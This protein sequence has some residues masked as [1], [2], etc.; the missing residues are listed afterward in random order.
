MP[1]DRRYSLPSPHS[2]RDKDFTV[3]HRRSFS[4]KRLEKQGGMLPSLWN[5]APPR[6]PESDGASL[7][8]ED[9]QK[10]LLR[11]YKRSQNNA[12]LVLWMPDRELHQTLINPLE[13]L[14]PWTLQSTIL[15]GSAS[16]MHIGWVFSKGPSPVD[17]ESKVLFDERRSRGAGSSAAMKFV[18]ERILKKTT[19]A[20]TY[21]SRRIVEPFIHRSGQMA[22]WS[23]RVGVKYVG[24]TT[25]KRT[26]AGVKE[27]LAQ[28]ELPG[29]QVRLPAT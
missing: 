25:S 28:V 13:D 2:H 21:D 20:W 23:R 7:T 1:D 19:G 9:L 11:T 15:S 26:Y 14:D 10:L 29:I 8:T 17:W 6:W 3:L 16:G 24:Y 27:K 18:L 12:H 4:F 22:L 5:I